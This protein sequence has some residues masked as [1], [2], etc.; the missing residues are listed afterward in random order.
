[1]VP[2]AVYDTYPLL[3]STWPGLIFQ[4]SMGKGYLYWP[5]K[6]CLKS[7]NAIMHR[8]RI[9][10]F[11][12]PMSEVLLLHYVGERGDLYTTRDL[13]FKKS[14]W[15]EINWLA[16]WI[17]FIP[18]THHMLSHSVRGFPYKI[19][20]IDHYTI[21]LGTLR[22]HACSVF[23]MVMLSGNETWVTCANTHGVHKIL[24]R[25]QNQMEMCFLCS[26]Q[27]TKVWTSKTQLNE[28]TLFF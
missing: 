11:K 14:D 19:I 7:K 18:H 6:A 27:G 4:Q 13:L 23:L 9:M 3:H 22:G 8:L 25:W 15:I 17:S 5:E 24:W 26:L 2:H 20:Y 16:Q 12:S 1:M 10:F 21:H 28:L